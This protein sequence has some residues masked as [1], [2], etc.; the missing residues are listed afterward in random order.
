MSDD[1]GRGSFRGEGRRLMMWR[2]GGEKNDG[3]W[4]GGRG[5]SGFRAGRR[6]WIWRWDMRFEGSRMRGWWGVRRSG[7]WG[8]KS[9]EGEEADQNP[10]N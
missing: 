8:R 7:S 2:V 3:E 1:R 9:G 10:E 4:W 5:K 6:R